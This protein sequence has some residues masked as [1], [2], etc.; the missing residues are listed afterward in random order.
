[1]TK[2][3][4]ILLLIGIF[5]ALGIGLGY[6]WSRP[7]LLEVSPA[8]QAQAVPAGAE[9][10]LT[11]SRRMQEESIQE[12]LHLEPP[13]EGVFRWQKNTLIFTPSHA[14]P[15]GGKIQAELE[16]GGKTDRFPVISLSEGRRWSF[17]I[18]QPRLAYLY[19]ANGPANI[20][21]LN[22]PSGESSPLTDSPGGVQDFAVSAS[23]TY[24]YYSLRTSQGSAIYR[25]DLE[26]RAVK[27]S[28]P[29]ASPGKT[30][31]T[32]EPSKP[33]LLLA[34]PEALCRSLAVSP[35]ED[36]LAYE[37]TALEG[38][39]QELYPQ[40]WYFPLSKQGE[41]TTVAE[42]PAPEGSQILAGQAQHQT[43]QPDWS[44]DGLLT[45][46]DSTSEA[47]IILNPAN[48]DQV[49]FPNQTGETGSW[50]PDGQVFVAPEINFLETG[51]G[52]QALANSGLMQYNRLDGSA[53]D[54]TPDDNME[55]TA[56]A[57]SPDGRFLAFTRKY[58]DITRWTPGRQIWLLRLDDKEARPLTSD[59]FYNHFML[60]WSP[61]SDQ[62][63]YMRFNQ[64]SPTE[65]PEIWLIDP[66][67]SQALQLVV[68]GYD[69]QWIP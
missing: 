23:G 32:A 11:F 5:L 20:Y 2:H 53:L 12:R 66:L 28:T 61:A 27:P 42:T 4:R 60:A 49:S 1:M 69:P 47:F 40:V 41:A 62:L 39:N 57:F 10:R 58:L 67:T 45:F 50:R 65:P 63:A 35:K 64:S 38:N 24:L 6:I 59:P 51:S 14:W 36:Y 9:L 21:V 33:A 25:L 48:K 16:A 68:G 29:E 43:L 31:S 44:P 55:D 13:V 3:L 18:R 37:R 34:C 7:R 19:P 46:Y 8:N 56:P 30:L 54:L 26:N 22:P 52:L 17:T 15:T